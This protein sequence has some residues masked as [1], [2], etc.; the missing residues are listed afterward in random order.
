MVKL[1]PDIMDKIHHCY[2]HKING[3]LERLM[4]SS[5]HMKLQ[6]VEVING[7]EQIVEYT[8]ERMHG[9]LHAFPPDELGEQLSPCFNCVSYEKNIGGCEGRIDPAGC[10]TPKHLPWEVK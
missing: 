3:K 8:I 2:V 5:P 10:F 1:S 4:V 6:F 9:E 7:S